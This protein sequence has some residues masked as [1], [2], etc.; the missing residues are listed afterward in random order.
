MPEFVP[1]Q[2]AQEI[3]EPAAVEMLASIQRC[4]TEVPAFG[5]VQT[6]FVG[7][8]PGTAG[9]YSLCILFENT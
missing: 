8:E 6:T 5:T 4:A 1:T 2:P 3:E 9:A 7:P